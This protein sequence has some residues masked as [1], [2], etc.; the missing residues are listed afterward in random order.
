MYKVKLGKTKDRGRGV[1]ALKSFKKG[2]MIEECPVI[3][4]TAKESLICD[5]TILEYYQ[6]PW[7]GEKDGAIV[8]GYG[9]LYSHSYNPNTEYFFR[10]NA[11]KM[12]YKALRP[13]KKGEEILVNYNGNPKDRDKMDFLVYHG[14]KVKSKHEID[15][16]Q[17]RG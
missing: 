16:L 3:P 2:E 5:Q 11:K 10:F 8:A 14:S 6:Y 12:I 13:I 1:F 15:K 7:R 17:V 4:L 9:M